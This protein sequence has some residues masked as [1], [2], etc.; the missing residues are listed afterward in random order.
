MGTPIFIHLHMYGDCVG[1]HSGIHGDFM[2]ILARGQKQA[3]GRFRSNSYSVVPTRKLAASCVEGK[4]VMS[5]VNL[6]R[7][8]ILF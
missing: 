3:Q 4:C 8:L 2:R 1:I 5:P 6:Q 7:L